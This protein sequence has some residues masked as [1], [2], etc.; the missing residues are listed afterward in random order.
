[1][2][3]FCDCLQSVIT[4]PMS[5]CTTRIGSIRISRANFSIFLRK[6][7]LNK[8]A[9]RRK[10]KQY[11]NSLKK[12][13][14]TTVT[15]LHACYEPVWLYYVSDPKLQSVLSV[16]RKTRNHAI[17]I[18]QRRNTLHGIWNKMWIIRG[19]LRAFFYHSLEHGISK[20]V[21]INSANHPSSE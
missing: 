10:K 14:F 8:R 11:L 7:A 5:P 17:R 15:T 1:M 18:P 6:V 9:K 20:H 19:M 12:K 3:H 2:I 13:S 4:S 21:N 16:L